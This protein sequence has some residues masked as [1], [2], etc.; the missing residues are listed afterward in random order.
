MK[1]R[2]TIRD[3]ATK[4]GIHHSTVSRALRGDSR[5]LSATRRR[6]QNAAKKMG[7]YPDPMLSALMIY[8]AKNSP[9]NFRGQLAVVTNYSTRDGWHQYEKVGFFAGA[10]RQA[11]ALGYEIEAHWLSEPGMTERRFDQILFARN[12]QGLLFIPQPRSHAHVRLD[13]EKYSGVSFG[14]TLTKPQLRMVDSDHYNSMAILMRQ[15]RKRGYR[16]PGLV[17][18]QRVNESINR[19]WVA[20][21]WAFQSAPPP[22]QLPVFAS[23]RL[24]RQEFEAWFHRNRPDVIVSHAEE[25]LTWIG[26]MGM[27]VPEDV[28][29]A[30]PARHGVPEFCAG[31]DENN[32]LIGEIAVNT[33]VSMIQHGERGIPATPVSTLVTGFWVEGDS[34]RAPA[35]REKP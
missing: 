20:A 10:K 18:L 22:E 17:C 19:Q 11:T 6:V 7:Y 33:V 27:K 8:R 12:I 25:C 34:L 35:K 2:V 15:L 26:E 31:I 28:G 32:E 30:T 9:T 1:S 23:D 3:I 29:F 4:L 13:W 16:K 21:F 24:E 14:P 5:I